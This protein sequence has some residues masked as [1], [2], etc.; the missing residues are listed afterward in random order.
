MKAKH[1]LVKCIAIY[2]LINLTSCREMT[3]ETEVR[4]AEE[5]VVNH[6]TPE[7]AF[8]GEEGVRKQGTLFGKEVTYAEIDGK[9]VFEGD[10]ILTPEQLGSETGARTQAL[11]KIV[12][13]W[14]N[15]T[16]SY[17]IDA[18]ITD[19]SAVLEAISQVEAFTPLRFVLRKPTP[20]LPGLPVL[21]QSYVTFKLSR[22]Y[23]SSI[24]RIGGEQFITIPTGATKG[25]ILHEIG[26]TVGLL[27]EHTR[28]DRDAYI[29]VNLNNV[30]DAAK[31]NLAIVAEESDEHVKHG[32][33]DF[34]SIMMM[35]S[36]AYSKNKLPVMT[37]TDNKTF[38][39][40]RDYLSDGDIYCITAMYANLFAV[41]P[42]HIWAGDAASGKWS[43][44]ATTW[45]NA[46]EI[47]ALPGTL[48]LSK[49]PNLMR[50]NARSG[51]GYSIASGF[52][53]VKGITY[54][55][56]NLFV[57]Q[58]GTVWKIDVASGARQSF[59]GPFWTSA[60]GLSY[61]FGLLYIVSGD[62][63]Y[64]ISSNGQSFSSIGSGYQG[65]TEMTGWKNSLYILKPNGKLYKVDPTN[66]DQKEYTPAT[67]APNAQL[68]SNGKN[69]LIASQGVL[70]SVDEN[71]WTKQIS[72]GWTSVT[73]ISAVS[74]ED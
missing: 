42:Y 66:G 10:M 39:V 44:L 16:V 28:P 15:N 14:P 58:N 30:A 26:H 48:F 74:S 33:F 55:R 54:Y 49:S 23:S 71:G 53:G 65:V 2:A 32:K 6:V 38:S 68:T 36:Y 52:S 19:Q 60:T 13:L 63:L 64:M 37:T 12:S 61:A 31:P 11:S 51:K 47:Y 27:H 34:K 40:Q 45:T 22:G 62:N 7:V 21:R 50:L 24:G 41:T 43:V 1:L 8:P 35:D 9:A 29:K 56:G 25:G 3:P 17:T 20:D 57:L 46:E 4:S 67:F 70:Y 73:D 18:S 72:L 59:T 69:L 5:T